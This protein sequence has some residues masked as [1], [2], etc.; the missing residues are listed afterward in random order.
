LAERN[1]REIHFPSL[2]KTIVFVFWAFAILPLPLSFATSP[3]QTNPSTIRSRCVDKA[4]FEEVV[5]A[6]ASVRPK[7]REWM[8][9]DI[10]GYQANLGD[11]ESAVQTVSLM[12]DQLSVNDTLDKLAIRQADVGDFRGA[13]S[14]AR[15]ITEK[16]PHTFV[17]IAAMEAETGD[18]LGAFQAF[19][20]LSFEDR[21]SILD[22]E[23]KYDLKRG[24]MTSA[25]KTLNEIHEK[26]FSLWA[27]MFA[28]A[29][30]GDIDAAFHTGNLIKDATAREQ[31]RQG[32]ANARIAA[33]DFEGAKRLAVGISIGFHVRVLYDVGEAQAKSGMRAAA[34]I[35]LDEAADLAFQ[36]SSLF[37]GNTL[38]TI[39]EHEIRLGLPVNAMKQIDA[40]PVGDEKRDALVAVGEAR[41]ATGEIKQAE[42]IFERAPYPPMVAVT[43][44]TQ[45]DL[46]GAL[47]AL[48]RSDSSINV[49]TYMVD[50]A[51]RLAQRGD[52][53]AALSVVPKIDGA[54]KH[55]YRS[56]ALQK[57][58]RARIKNGDSA[59]TL[60]WARTERDSLFRAMALLG[61]LEGNLENC[62]PGST[63]PLI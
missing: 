43:R 45:G 4:T 15:K 3:R 9:A 20:R 21:D 41:L 51:E 60:Q 27:I 49:D 19:P 40:L 37:R 6:V 17:Q 12:K 36:D 30:S 63:S 35:S 31:V 42:A 44:A 23:V 11:F 28:Q 26:D 18:A 59:A 56:E 5:S 52:V 61:A 54:M 16:Y 62:H 46:Q 48:H 39:S 55:T 47:D 38:G 29:E 50:I 33:G 34:E 58:A 24:K 32:I 2:F 1:L 13:R 8:L 7:D 10:A 25:L 53:T 22:A 57:I 14:T